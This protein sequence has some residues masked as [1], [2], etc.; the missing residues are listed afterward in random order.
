[1]FTLID[2]ENGVN[3]KQYRSVLTV[4]LWNIDVNQCFF[5]DNLHA[6]LQFF[7]LD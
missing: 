6:K 4:L 2:N 1:M 7:S 5:V 3:L